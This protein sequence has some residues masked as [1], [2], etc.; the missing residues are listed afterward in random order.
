MTK[1]ANITGNAEIAASLHAARRSP[2]PA[3]ALLAVADAI[4]AN[5]AQKRRAEAVRFAAKRLE[6][7]PFDADAATSISAAAEDY[8]RAAR[9]DSM[10]AAAEADMD[11]VPHNL[12]FPLARGRTPGEPMQRDT[13]RLTGRNPFYGRS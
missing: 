1:P 11:K 3:E 5:P 7:D 12:T 13:T 10:E 8:A 4:A 6:A 2:N 9:W